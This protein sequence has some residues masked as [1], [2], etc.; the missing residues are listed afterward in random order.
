VALN[1]VNLTLN[2]GEVVGVIGE[3]GSGKSTLVRLLCF[4][5]PPTAGRA[6]FHETDRVIELCALDAARQRAFRDTHFR[7]VYQNPML[8]LDLSISAGGNIAERLIASERLRYASLRSRARELLERT[9][10]PAKR[11]DEPPK[12]FSRGMQQRV[13]IAKALATEPPL[14]LLDEITTG[15]DLSVQARI[16]DL[17]LELQEQLA[18]SMLVVTHD[19][20]VVRHLASRT[21]VMRHGAVVEAGLTDQILEDPHHPYT[22]ELVSAAL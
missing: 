12:R 15:L 11:M 4:D 9:G 21:L 2:R 16:L 6:V 14:L 7:V 18:V 3:S 17:V 5:E 8:G 22:Q 10:V 1:R 13:Q 19:L 20:G